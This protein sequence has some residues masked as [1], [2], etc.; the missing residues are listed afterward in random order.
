MYQN[1]NALVTA[2]VSFNSTKGSR[3]Y[4]TREDLIANN[5]VL[6]QDES[7]T[8]FPHGDAVGI[9][10]LN[11]R[12]AKLMN[13]AVVVTAPLHPQSITAGYPNTSFMYTGVLPSY[14][15]GLKSNFNAAWPASRN[16]S[17]NWAQEGSFMRFVELDTLS[18]VLLASCQTEYQKRDQR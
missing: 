4:F 15:G 10:L 3:S 2:R 16:L 11:D 5:K 13:N 7:L 1:L 14:S 12:D 6:I 8:A 18:Q 9:T 17:G